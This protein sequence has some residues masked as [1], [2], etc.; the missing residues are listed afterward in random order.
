MIRLAV[1]VSSEHAELVL[2]ELLTL[3]PAGVEEAELAPGVI[4]YAVYGA[5]GEL[6]SL[7]DLHAVAGDALVEVRTT[8]VAE[9]WSERWKQFHRP[10]LIPA[11]AGSTGVPAVYVRPPWEPPRGAADGIEIEIDPGQAFGTGGHATTRLCLE[12]LLAHAGLRGAR[13]AVLDVGTGSGVLAIAAS[14]LGYAPV[15]ALDNEPESV[16]A[17]CENARVNGATVEV[18]RLDLRSDP[19]RWVGEEPTAP[20]L[21][22]ANLL[23]PLLELLASTLADGPALPGDLVAGGLLDHEAPA[24]ARAFAQAAGME[25]V[26]SREEGGW[27]ALWLA[28]PG[29][30]SASSVAAHTLAR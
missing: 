30:P 24:V 15:L 14:R 22:L 1:R 21:V 27:A 23:A 19:L 12:L 26:R 16:N 8:E 4:E 18:R 2:A 28:R 10:V 6:P 5:P 9:D 7:P 29:Q 17:A 13:G 20:T 3:C 11:P 25:V